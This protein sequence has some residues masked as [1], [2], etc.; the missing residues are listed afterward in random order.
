MNKN[1]RINTNIS[2]DTILNVNMQQDF[3]FLEVLTMKLGQK[4]AYK[5]HSSNYGVIIGRVL[6]ND[7]FGIPNAKVSLFIERSSDD[8][9]TI[10]SLYPYSE[11]TTKDNEG[12]RYNLLPDYSD[13]DCY[14][15]VGTFPNKRL[16]LDNNSQLEIYDKYWKYTTV[17]N[18]AGDYMLFGVPNGNQQIH[19]D[20]DLSDIGVLSQKPRDFLYK[21][22][23]ISMFDSSSQFKEST[24]L[25]GLTQLFSQDKSVFV[26]PFWGDAD[27]DIVAITRCD[28]QIQYK[29]E[30]TCVFMGAIMSDNEGNAIGNACVPGKGTGMNSQLVAG[31]GTIEMIRKTPDGLIEEYNIQGNQLIDSDGV[32]CYQIPMNLDF[33]GTDEYGNI[34]PTDNPSKGIPTRTQVR[35]RF[36]KTETGNEGFSRH[37]AKYLVPMNPNFD[38]EKVVPT[39]K[40][41]GQD[42]EKMY[43]FGSSTPQNCFRDLYWNNVYSVK[44][45][46]PKVQISNKLYSANYSALKGSNLVD[47]QNPLPFNKLRIDMPFL[48]IIVCILFSIV[49]LVV[50]IVNIIITVINSIIKIFNSIRNIKILWVKPFGWLPKIGYVGC[51]SLGGGLSEDNTAYYPSCGKEGMDAADCPEGMEGCKKSASPGALRDKV[52]QKLAEDFEIVKLDFYQ[53]WINGCLFMPLWYWRKR[54]KKKFLFWTISSA[55]NDFCS[56][57]SIYSLKAYTNCNIAYT[58]ESLGTND[59][60]LPEKEDSWH[61]SSKRG[62]QI[63]YRRGLIKGVTNKDDLTVYYYAAL[64]AT[65]DNVNPNL[66]MENRGGNFKAI[67]LFATDIIL[68]GNLNEENIYGIPQFFKSLPATTA[69][70]PPIATL[71][72]DA[73]TSENEKEYQNEISSTEDSGITVTTGMDWQ[74]DGSSDSPYYKKGLFMDLECTYADTKAKSC[75]NVERLSEFGVNLDMAYNMSYPSGNEIRTGFVDTDGFVTK[76]ELDDLENRAMFAT[77]N[78]IGFVPQEYQD[79]ISGYTTQIEDDRTNYM[80]PKFKFMY[81][82]DFDGRMNVLLERY[83]NGFQQ[84]MLDA[85]DEEYITFRMG[86]TKSGSTESENI[87]HG[88]K[89]HFYI[90]QPNRYEMPLY[91]NSFYFYFGVNKGSTAIDKFNNMFFAECVKNDKKPFSLDINYKGV[92]YCPS[93]YSNNKGY[94]Y[95]KISSDD[96]QMPYSYTLYN[97][98]GEVVISENNMT[99][100]TFVIGGTIDDDGNVI[101]NEEGEIKYQTSEDTIN[102]K[103]SNQTYNL[104]VK[105]FYGKTINERIVLSMDKLGIEYTT[106]RLGTKFYD[107]METPMEYICN[108]INKYYGVIDISRVLIDSYEFEIDGAKMHEYKEDSGTFTIAFYCKS[109]EENEQIFSKRV[110]IYVEIK[111]TIEG[112]DINECLCNTNDDSDADNSG[113]ASYEIDNVIEEDEKVRKHLFINVYQPITYSLTITQTCDNDGEQLKDNK[114]TQLVQISNGNN[115][116]TFLNGMPI[117]FMLGTTNDTSAATIANDSNFYSSS[118]SSQVKITNDKIN[119]DII[120]WFGVHQE[121]TYKFDTSKNTTSIYNK[122]TWEDFFTFKSGIETINSRKEILRFKFEKMFDLSNIVY[123]MSSSEESFRYTYVGGVEPILVRTLAPYYSNN[124]LATTT[125]LFNDNGMVT[126]SKDKPNIVGNYYIGDSGTTRYN[127]NGKI[128]PRFNGLWNSASTSTYLGNYFAAFTKNGRYTASTSGDCSISI[129]ALPNYAPVNLVNNNWKRLGKSERIIVDTL[130]SFPRAARV[131]GST[132]GTCSKMTQPYL[133]ALTVDRR[134]GYDLE[135]WTPINITN[136]KLHDSN[137]LENI[138]KSARIRGTIYGGVEMSYDEDYNIIS[139][140]TE[141]DESG[142]ITRFIPNKRL[143]YSYSADTDPYSNAI[144][145]YNIP[146][147]NDVTWGNTYDVIYEYL[148]TKQEASDLINSLYGDIDKQILKTFHNVEFNGVNISQLFWST[149]NKKQLSAYTSSNFNNIE[150]LNVPY[151]Y[152]HEMDDDLYNGDFNLKEIYES[153]DSSYPTKRYIDIGNLSYLNECLFSLTSCG[154][155]I[156]PQINE[157]GLITATATSGD[158]IE[159]DIPITEPFEFIKPVGAVE[160]DSVL[161]PNLS[162]LQTT[163]Y[164][165]ISNEDDEYDE[166]VKFAGDKLSLDFKYKKIDSNGYEIITSYPRLI[167]VLSDRFSDGGVHETDGITYIKTASKDIYNFTGF[168]RDSSD[169][170]TRVLGSVNDGWGGACMNRFYF[171]YNS[172]GG[173]GW[174]HGSRDVFDP[175]NVLSYCV[176]KTKRDGK[177]DSMKLP[178]YFYLD[179]DAGIVT[180]DVEAFTKIYFRRHGIPLTNTFNNHFVDKTRVFT[181]MVSRQYLSYDSDTLYKRLTTYETSSLFDARDIFI[182]KKVEYVDSTLYFSIRKDYYVLEEDDIVVEHLHFDNE[183][184]AN[185]E[186]D[187]QSKINP[188]KN[189]VVKFIDPFSSGALNYINQSFSNK[190]ITSIMFKFKDTNGMEYYLDGQDEESLYYERKVGVTVNSDILADKI[191]IL[192]YAKMYNGFVYCLS[193]GESEPF[194]LVKEEGNYIIKEKQRTNG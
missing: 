5:L 50:Q 23:N 142:E 112:K 160:D 118:A 49:M 87:E 54:K 167:N 115:F 88:R 106:V 99:A 41:S 163:G 43:A 124:N 187:K 25:D 77:L 15:I 32:W 117:K 151:L 158:E 97:S 192:I 72:E 45:Y 79:S 16:V 175:E 22:Y 11:I 137:N 141:Y 181:L 121:T 4:D 129:M 3:D 75:I 1:F 59:A 114:T 156:N 139:A 31:E 35:F 67:R 102:E 178:Y 29:F 153:P 136:F 147:A 174:T 70:I 155:S 111:P 74:R 30:P 108:K 116:N 90:K 64:Q 91:N 145:I 135:I 18:N 171:M 170:D 2:N 38:E 17:T 138:W 159:L 144:T 10:E 161:Y 69:N 68:L 164:T 56:C 71:Q 166:Y 37:T 107:A 53:D 55:K 125:Y 162:M 13:D 143:E 154:Y 60:N 27:N 113:V 173:Y 95:I 46:I 189:Y 24:N 9:E 44:N 180:T 132:D 127:N 130:D 33:V 150:I 131:S 8:V 61:R 168:T 176:H 120:G 122:N 123:V 149:F 133:R 172:N 101:I 62:G 65:T 84:S 148:S 182:N 36:S 186:K 177:D 126:I 58:D 119:K 81:P 165:R 6:A 98:L 152:K 105:D 21:G 83:K 28:I 169:I 93:I 26:Y 179:H 42:I 63:K 128:K 184:D 73:N 52:Q 94:G 48:Y 89:R 47:K 76:Y 51:V 86:A 183:I 66:P 34:V 78:H 7:A 85:T 40:M 140:N 14:R 104:T 92:S 146:N 39:V 57:D 96:I 134:I 100:S 110:V 188:D 19:I 103:L 157:E 190:T 185:F 194:I 82:V 80:I 193:R 12:R 191:E 109:I 20:I